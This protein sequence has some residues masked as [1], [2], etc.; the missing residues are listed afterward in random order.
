MRGDRV[1]GRSFGEFVKYPRTPHLF[2]SKGTDDDKHMGEADSHH[3]LS[4]TSL[5]AEEKLDGTNVGI[6]F[7]SEGEIVLQ[8]RGH[9]ITEGMH[10]QYDL[11]KQWAAVKRPVLE[12]RLMDRFILFGEWLFARHSIH[13]KKLPHYFFEFDVYDKEIEDF[14]GLERRL[15]LLEG[16]SLHTVPVIHRGSLTRDRLASLIGPSRFEGEFENPLTGQADQLMEGLYLRTEANGLVTGR[17]KLVRFE[18]VQ[19]VKQSEHWQHQEMTSNRLEEGA[20]IWS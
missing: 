11:F 18:F 3:F 7:T 1:T 20:D 15:A 9:F 2:G 19:K 5:I 10:P 16:I 13:Y 6:H 14:L 12:D 8:C 17:A 4:D